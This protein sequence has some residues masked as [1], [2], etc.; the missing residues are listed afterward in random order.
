MAK[1]TNNYQPIGFRNGAVQFSGADTTTI[2]D[3]L[4]AGADDS[5]IT[6]ISLT[7]DSGVPENIQLFLFDGAA[8]HIIATI[9]IPAGAGTNGSN[10]TVDGLAG[11]W[12]PLSAG[13]RVITLQNGWKLQAAMLTT[14]SG[15]IE[16]SAT[17]QDY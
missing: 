9:R 1:Q 13:K 5:V 3:I 11:A 6:S 12:F 8:S 17:A 7:S 10:A 14:A 16:F 2:K 15:N 4:A